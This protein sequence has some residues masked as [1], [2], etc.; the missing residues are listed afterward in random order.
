MYLRIFLL[1]SITYYSFSFKVIYTMIH[2]QVLLNDGA[3]S[4]DEKDILS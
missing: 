3:I 2:E 1:S 4:N